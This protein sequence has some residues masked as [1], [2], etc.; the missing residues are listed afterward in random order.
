MSTQ[1]F[2][3]RVSGLVL[4][5]EKA[6]A[7][8]GGSTPTDPLTFHLYHL[9]RYWSRLVGFCRHNPTK[10][11]AFMETDLAVCVQVGSEFAHKLIGL[12]SPIYARWQEYW[13]QT[14]AMLHRRPVTIE[15][16]EAASLAFD[17]C[18][19][20]LKYDPWT[21]CPHTGSQGAVQIR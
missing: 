1:L 7:A 16:I 14:Q 10:V 17:R 2:A 21:N 4:E 6:F 20:D 11:A 19:A 12:N 15:A 3:E 8:R 13:V 18:V 5:Y 9:A